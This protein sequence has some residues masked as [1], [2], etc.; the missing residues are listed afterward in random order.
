MDEY[1]ITDKEKIKEIFKKYN[2][3]ALSTE[4][5]ISFVKLLGELWRII[6][7][8]KKSVFEVRSDIYKKK[9]AYNIHKRKKSPNITKLTSRSLAPIG[10]GFHIFLR[11]N[12]L[13]LQ[14]GIMDTPRIDISLDAAPPVPPIITNHE[15]SNEGITIF[16]QDYKPFLDTY[17][18][19]KNIKL[20][21]TIYYSYRAFLPK[22]YLENN[23]QQILKHLYIETETKN[24][25]RLR[26]DG[27]VISVQAVPTQEKL[28]VN[29]IIINQALIP[30][31][32]ISY[33]TIR[34][35]MDTLLLPDEF[36]PEISFLSNVKKVVWQ[37]SETNSSY[38]DIFEKCK[39][40]TATNPDLVES[41]QPVFKQ[42]SKGIFIPGMEIY[43]TEDTP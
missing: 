4:K 9:N 2:L 16:W 32:Y 6:P 12:L 42:Y 37:N 15:I 13:G 36:L 31:K 35:Q 29:Y 27:R 30:L 23:K 5:M 39:K 11:H 19:F 20:F 33:A 21:T 1:I 41:K 18:H 14:R 3:C 34:F 40:L 8:S 7:D 38:N 10:F 22:K 24:Y 17:A 26:S 25:Y 28:H 43:K